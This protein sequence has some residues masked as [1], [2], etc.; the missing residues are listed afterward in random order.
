MKCFI[1]DCYIGI[2]AVDEAGN[3]INFQD[4]NEDREQKI[5]FFREI[6]NKTLTREYKTF[7]NELV[8]SGFN[9]FLFDNKELAD[10]TF[11]EL[12]YTSNLV[13]DSEE[14]K[15]FRFNLTSH[16][17]RIG[18][19]KS[20]A[21]LL[22]EYKEISETL[23]KYHV[24]R[25]GE[26]ED[27]MIIQTIETIDQIKK[28][29]SSFTMRLRE[30]YGLYFPE[31]T[32]KIIDDEIVLAQI[33]SYLG[34]RASFTEENLK[35]YFNFSEHLVQS[36]QEKA[37]TSMGAEIDI[38]MMQALA[39]Q[40]LSL[41]EYR[42][43]LEDYLSRLME[44]VAPNLTAVIGSL[45]GAKLMAKAGSLK[46]VAFMPASR[47]QLLG[48]EKALYRFLKTGQKVPKH[49]LI[50]QWN[51]IRGSPASIRGNIARLIANKI[52]IAAKIDYFGGDFKGELLSQEINEKIKMI[53]KKL[54]R[55]KKKEEISSLPVP[56]KK[57]KKK[58]K[59]KRK[60][61]GKT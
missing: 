27:L 1:I 12:G 18:I 29:I 37:K 25:A 31:L 15:N 13:K 54:P 52:A 51:Q 36:L 60:K 8:N 38:S 26:A 16:L 9:Q 22:R 49:G 2:F 58:N 35:N 21:D 14:F 28:S 7:L 45:I 11:S 20:Q 40:I 57:K 34:E 59:K 43:E 47:I 55:K 32:D 33:I 3:I 23:I 39:N 53:K 42:V 48:A 5:A 19:H 56:K 46:K 61:Y 6:K 4:F 50:F 44:Q 24:S 10:L 41:N 17:N 30:W